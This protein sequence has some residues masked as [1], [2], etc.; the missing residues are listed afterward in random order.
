[1]HPPWHG[2]QA[3]MTRPMLM[4]P[5][6]S[7]RMGPHRI[8]GLLRAVED[9]LLDIRNHFRRPYPQ[10]VKWQLN[11]NRLMPD[12]SGRAMCQCTGCP[13]PCLVV[14]VKPYHMQRCMVPLGSINRGTHHRHVRALAPTW[15]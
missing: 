12:T 11:P 15:A 13:V 1:M 8:K 2:L 4:T 10:E 9:E 6:P 5:V 7:C 3:S 14:G